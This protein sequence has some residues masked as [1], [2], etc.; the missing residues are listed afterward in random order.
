MKPV[1]KSSIKMHNR[2]DDIT[3]KNF[4][5][6]QRYSAQNYQNCLTDNILFFHRG[7]GAF[8]YSNFVIP[9]FPVGVF[10]S[11]QFY[12]PCMGLRPTLI[13]PQYQ[14]VPTSK[15]GQDMIQKEE[16]STPGT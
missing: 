11:L 16:P 6:E 15:E 9:Q 7:S 10:P 3:E 12:N 8:N 1:G 14:N 2:A 13:L 5:Q 4:A